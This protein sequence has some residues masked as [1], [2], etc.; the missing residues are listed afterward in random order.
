MKSILIA[1]VAGIVG[2]LVGLWTAPVAH[3]Q[4]SA[5]VKPEQLRFHI[6]GDEPLATPDGR[7]FANGWKVFVLRDMKADQC[8][9]S[10]VAGSAMS[11]TGPAA[12][13]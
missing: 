5:I 2:A 13:P 8:Y 7:N 4:L 9:V 3:A 1:I 10:F 12:C 6:V 11:T